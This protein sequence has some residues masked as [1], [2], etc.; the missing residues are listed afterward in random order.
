MH[1]IR[2]R[3]QNKR[4]FNWGFVSYVCLMAVYTASS[5]WLCFES[6]YVYSIYKH[7]K[8]KLC[9]YEYVCTY[10]LID[11]HICTDRHMYLPNDKQFA[12]T[13][14][15]HYVGTDPRTPLPLPPPPSPH[16]SSEPHL[17]TGGQVASLHKRCVCVRACVRSCVWVSEWGSTIK[18][19]RNWESEC[20][21]L[22]INE[23]GKVEGEK[24][25]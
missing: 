1:T 23:V 22:Y 5:I 25:E 4:N 21:K 17:K 3:R 10:I 14:Q 2:N 18:W 24:W 19:V 16:A 20:V 6:I 9:T 8:N 12:N 15:I 7:L 13:K 11:A